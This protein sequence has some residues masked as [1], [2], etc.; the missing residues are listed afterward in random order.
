M[1]GPELG[2]LGALLISVG[3]S[4]MGEER[5]EDED[6]YAQSLVAEAEAGA[7]S[8]GRKRKRR[9]RVGEWVSLSVE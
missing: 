4:K 8:V 9:R 2:G 3:D 1:A 5:D 6:M 7:L